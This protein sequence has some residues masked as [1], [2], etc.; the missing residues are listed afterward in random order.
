MQAEK[1]YRSRGAPTWPVGNLPSR[2]PADCST[3]AVLLSVRSRWQPATPFF[4]KS[5]ILAPLAVFP[6]KLK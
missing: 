3:G 1:V 6:K 4:T 5:A 2:F